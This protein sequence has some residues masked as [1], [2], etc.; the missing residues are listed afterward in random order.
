MLAEGKWQINFVDPSFSF[1]L[2]FIWV[3]PLGI[4]RCF[5]TVCH[6]DHQDFTKHELHPH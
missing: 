2:N 1:H 3:S 6:D 4:L 5:H